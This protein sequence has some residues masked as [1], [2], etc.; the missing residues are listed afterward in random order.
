[1]TIDKS[2]LVPTTEEDK[3]LAKEYEDKF[4]AEGREFERFFLRDQDNKED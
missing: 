1:M 3:K 4:K 2:F